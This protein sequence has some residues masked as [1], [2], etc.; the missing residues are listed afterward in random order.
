MSYQRDN[1]RRNIS[2]YGGYNSYNRNNNNHNTN[3]WGTSEYGYGNSSGYGNNS[4]YGYNNN[5]NSDN[6]NNNYYSN[7]INNQQGQWQ[8]GNN[9]PS[10]FTASYQQ[11]QALAN[12]IPRRRQ[13]NTHEDEHKM[14]VATD[15]VSPV[16]ERDLNL[17]PMV[18]TKDWT[19]YTTE[20]Q[21]KLLVSPMLVKLFF[22]ILQI[23]L[24]SY[25]FFSF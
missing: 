21:Y 13:S 19:L 5:N 1:K 23:I 16:Q 9:N 6:N 22:L 8:G 15:N 25:S 12:P 4:S 17:I 2:Q 14:D 24:Y 11:E 10:P 7:N 18:L 3:R 20:E